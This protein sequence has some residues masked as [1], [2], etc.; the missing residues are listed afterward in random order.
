[1]VS[2]LLHGSGWAVQRPGPDGLTVYESQDAAMDAARAELRDSGGVL[3]VH[4]RDGRLRE[5][6]TLGRSRIARINAVEGVSLSRET[7]E[8]FRQF[9][10]DGGC[11]WPS[12]EARRLDRPTLWMPET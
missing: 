12:S 8:Q 6:L 7:E 2:V 10:R 11:C 9:D 5:S 1:M 4:G 3:C